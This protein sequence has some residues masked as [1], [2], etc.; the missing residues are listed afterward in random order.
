MLIVVLLLALAPAAPKTTVR[1]AVA[2][3]GQLCT[4]RDPDFSR[5]A[6]PGKVPLCRR[7]VTPSI[8][9]TA[10]ALYGI[11]R[12]QWSKFELDHWVP[13]ALGGSNSVRNLFPQLL[14]DASKKDRLE[15][16]LY[17]ALKAGSVSQADAVSQMLAWH[18]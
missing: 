8:R 18:P 16:R 2:T 13:L 1:D 5:L 4:S 17:R 11:P 7:H 6:Y 12:A 14:R 15:N 10:F 9:K 3:P